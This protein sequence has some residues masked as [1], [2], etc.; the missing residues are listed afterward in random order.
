MRGPGVARSNAN[1]RKK[2]SYYSVPESRW[3]GARAL[4]LCWCICLGGGAV[5]GQTLVRIV[6][7]HLQRAGKALGKKYW[8]KVIRKARG[9][10]YTAVSRTKTRTGLLLQ[11]DELPLQF[12]AARRLDVLAEMARLRVLHEETH[13]RVHG[14]PD[15]AVQ[16]QRRLAAAERERKDAVQKFRISKR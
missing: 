10:F 5:Q 11:I 3:G 9:W 8:V 13:T 15:T 7:S 16:D 4:S 14:T 1:D 2:P 12:M 6:V